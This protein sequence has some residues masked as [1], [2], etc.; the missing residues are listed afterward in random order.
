[1]AP[2]SQLN[3]PKIPEK[4]I[5]M[6]LIDFWG[7][8]SGFENALPGIPGFRVLYGARTIAMHSFVFSSQQNEHLDAH[9]LALLIMLL[10]T[11]N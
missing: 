3:G 1:M 11:Q 2:K 9:T 8:F 6:P 5:R 10:K 4:C 7:A